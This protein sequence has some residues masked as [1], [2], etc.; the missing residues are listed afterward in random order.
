MLV[1]PGFR[2]IVRNSKTMNVPKMHFAPGFL[3]YCASACVIEERWDYE[4]HEHI[5]YRAVNPKELKKYEAFTFS[6][7]KIN[8]EFINSEKIAEIEAKQIKQENTAPVSEERKEESA[9]NQV[10]EAES[11]QG[12]LIM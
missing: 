2:K 9:D 4:E 11:D 1:I 8:E 6:K 5:C 10:I 3:H 7:P 12:R